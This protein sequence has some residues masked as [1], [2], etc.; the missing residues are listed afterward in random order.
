MKKTSKL[1]VSATGDSLMV[2]PFP[3]NYARDLAEIREFLAEADVRLTNLETNIA[4]FGDF[5][6][7]FSGGT[8]LNTEPDT[9][10]HLLGYGFNYFGTANN[11]ALD[12]SY[13]GLLST[14]KTLDRHRLAHSGSGR[15]LEEAARPAVL[16]TAGGKVAVIAVATTI[17]DPARA[18]RKS[19]G[20]AARPGV[21][22]VRHEHYYGLDATDLKALRA[23]ADKCGVNAYRDMC[24]ATGYALPDPEG[25]FSF[26]PLKFCGK[27][28]RP[29]SK[30]NAEDLAR[31]TAS[32][33][34]AKGSFDYV[35]VLVHCH[36]T[37]GTDAS[38]A[39]A[40]LQ[41]LA[42]ACVDAGASAIFGGGTHQ[43]RPL[44]I[45]N[46]APIFYS[47]GDFIY[48]GMRVKYLP[49]DFME[50]YGVADD[51]TAWEGLMAR[52]KGGKIGLQAGIENF[53]TVLPRVR[54]ENGGLVSLEM[55]PVDLAFGRRDFRNGLPRRARGATA[56]DIFDRLSSISAP[57]G[58]SLRLERGTIRLAPAE[59]KC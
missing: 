15:S 13:F 52:S 6:S 9:F 21:N 20:F 39:P 10:E 4:P 43:L 34:D 19:L 47:L 50:K 57:F 36:E 18:G 12:Y 8:W 53:L 31:L 5:N 26:G 30:C 46:G 38:E 32:V 16:N 40:L 59:K 3:D 17:A 7:A 28:A 58:T 2:A 27:G 55:L 56:R 45:Y 41:E 29:K 11:H 44:E 23:L 33:R 51:A 42:R 22:Y 14:L 25:I 54:F 24:V 1:T 48:Q 37:D 35:F 49:A